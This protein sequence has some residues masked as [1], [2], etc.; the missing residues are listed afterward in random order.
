MRRGSVWLGYPYGNIQLHCWRATFFP[1]PACLAQV[2]VFTHPLPIFLSHHETHNK[3]ITNTMPAARRSA[4]TNAAQANNEQGAGQQPPVEPNASTGRRRGNNRAPAAAR[5]TAAAM[6]EL[7]E[8]LEEQRRE[9][10]ELREQL[11]EALANLGGQA[12]GGGGPQGQQN[13]S[14]LDGQQGGQGTGNDGQQGPDIN[15]Q[16]SLVQKSGT[17]ES[18]D[19]AALRMDMDDRFNAIL[20]AISKVQPGNAQ[21]P[22]QQPAPA[23]PTGLA[24]Q[25]P[26][27]F[28]YAGLTGA[29]AGYVM[30]QM[31]MIGSVPSGGESSIAIHYTG[32]A[33]KDLAS[34][35]EGDIDPRKVYLAIPTDSD[36]YPK[37]SVKEKARL[38][39]DGEGQLTILD[40][41]KAQEDERQFKRLLTTLPDP[42]HFILA[43]SW[44]VTLTSYHYKSPPLAAAMMRFGWKVV[45]YSRVYPWETCLRTYV[46]LATRMLHG[47]LMESIGAFDGPF[48]DAIGCQVPS[49]ALAITN[50]T[51]GTGSAAIPTTK[52]AAPNGQTDSAKSATPTCLNF[53]RGYC[54]R[55]PCRFLHKCH[56]C[57]FY[58]HGAAHCAKPAGPVPASNGNGDNGANTGNAQAGPS[59]YGNRGHGQGASN[60]QFQSRGA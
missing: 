16:P 25:V 4:R 59:G 60:A 57:G 14:G 54:G 26:Q 32:L 39:F 2:S 24:A 58:G 17:G 45:A 1:L 50:I 56:A 55:V 53:N 20:A 3:T 38:E 48:S 15:S 10:A 27:P 36:L 49:S 12:N 30:P 31:G 52:P 8:Q 44:F 41:G 46:T 28:G 37:P 23:F 22:G 42:L 5:P 47:R 13:D 7:Q 9:G 40:N 19:V 21:I 34:I 11:R 6:R 29:Q 18:Q 35:M 33:K 43:W 51:S